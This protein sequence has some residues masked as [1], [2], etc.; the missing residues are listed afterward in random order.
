MNL[1]SNT[2]GLKETVVLAGGVPER[3]RAAAERIGSEQ[4]A[5]ST[6]YELE[7]LSPITAGGAAVDVRAARE[8]ATVLLS[9]RP[10]F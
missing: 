7:Y 10:P 9:V 2:G 5:M 4:R 6:R 8:G 1:V 3:M